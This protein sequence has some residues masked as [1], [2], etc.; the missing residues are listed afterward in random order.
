MP[1]TSGQTTGP[2]AENACAVEP[3]AVAAT[4]PSQPNDD[5]G[6]PSTSS[7]RPRACG[8]RSTFSSAASLSAHPVPMVPSGRSTRTSSVAAL[9]DVELARGQ[10]S[11]GLADVLALALGEEPDVPE[12]DPEQRH[13][14]PPREL[15]RPQDRPV[16]AEHDGQLE[17]RQVRR[18]RRPRPPA[19]AL[20]AG[21]L[22]LADGVA[23]GR[24]GLLAAA[25]RDDQCAP[26]SSGAPRRRAARRP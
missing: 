19:T 26:A 18:R 3:V 14:G 25:V 17:R 11:H 21:P 22:Q 2:P 13:G 15:G 5:S 4:T 1:S 20:D 7:E 16:T 6:W 9:L 10:P 8:T 24:H 23:G 12:V